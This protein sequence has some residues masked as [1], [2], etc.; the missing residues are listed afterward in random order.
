MNRAHDLADA[1][2]GAASETLRQEAIVTRT[3]RM[4][5]HPIG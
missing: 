3:P 1:A 5:N 4:L 2:F